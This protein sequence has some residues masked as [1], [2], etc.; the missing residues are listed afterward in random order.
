[1]PAV[2]ARLVATLDR[3]EAAVL[4]DATRPRP[5]PLAVRRSV[6]A[7][8]VDDLVAA[9]ERRLRA[10]LERLDVGIVAEKDWRPDDPAG[11]SL[12]DVDVPADLPG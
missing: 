5:L 6:A 7:S 2:L 11:E 8:A 10:L 12:R 9:G 3:R 4:A 1:V